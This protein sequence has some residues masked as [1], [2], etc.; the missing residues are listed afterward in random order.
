MTLEGDVLACS[1]RHCYGED[2]GQSL[3]FMDDGVGE[4]QVRPVLDL[5]LTTSYHTA[6]LLPDLVW[7]RGKMLFIFKVDPFND[8]AWKACLSEE[9][10]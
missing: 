2:V 3:C 1:V 9:N 10:I 6:Q 4:G 7:N 8:V 5:N